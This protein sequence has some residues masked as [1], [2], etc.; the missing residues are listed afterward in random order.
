MFG[1]VCE[2]SCVDCGYEVVEIGADAP[3]DRPRCFV[4]EW[5]IREFPEPVDRTTIRI[6]VG[7]VPLP[8]SRRKFLILR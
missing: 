8:P 4:C 6:L 2:W 5:I 3:P 7:A 1:S